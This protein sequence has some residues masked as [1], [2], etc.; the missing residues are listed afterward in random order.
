M[1]V[2]GVTST[3]GASSMYSVGLSVCLSVCR[4]SFSAVDTPPGSVRMRSLFTT[5]TTALASWEQR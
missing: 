2:Y 1:Y 4:V 5:A 3:D